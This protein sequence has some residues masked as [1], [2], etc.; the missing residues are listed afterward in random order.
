MVGSVIKVYVEENNYK[1]YY[2]D[3]ESMIQ[4]K[5]VNYT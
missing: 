4:D 3:A 2:V 5:I 1:N